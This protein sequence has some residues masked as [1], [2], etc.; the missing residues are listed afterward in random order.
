MSAA[1]IKAVMFD[2]DGTL[3]DTL[4]DLNE[5]AGRMLMTAGD[6]R[7][8]P[9]LTRKFVGNGVR[10]LTE[11]YLEHYGISSGEAF[12]DRCVKEFS[13]YYRENCCVKSALYPGAEELLEF[14]KDRQVKTVLCTMKP[15]APAEKLLQGLGIRKYFCMVL[16]G[17]T[18]ARP[19]PD[20]WC[21]GHVSEALGLE[22]G[23]VAVVGD[24][25][26]DTQM[27]RN[28]G[29][30][31]I[32]MLGG[33]TEERVMAE[34][35]ADGLARSLEEVREILADRIKNGADCCGTE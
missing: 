23:S 10:K 3:I 27:A 16:A 30:F 7:A 20:P 1:E 9:A 22:N 28:A 35:G 29:A 8:E 24:G 32:G 6:F 26:T 17:D 18:M 33:Y 31:S 11:R 25:L 4:A 14:L 12:L 13:D 15:E 19:K 5:A 34:S 2:L 21:V